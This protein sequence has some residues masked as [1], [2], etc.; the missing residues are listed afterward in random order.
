MVLGSLLSGGLQAHTSSVGYENAGPGAVTF[1]YGTYHTGVSA[2]EGSLLVTSTGGYSATVPFTLLVGTKPTGLIDGTTNFYSDGT[3]LVGTYSGTIHYWQGA[4]FTGLT[5]DTYTFTYQPITNPSSTWEPIDSVI[6]SSSVVLTSADL[7]GGMFSPNANT[8]SGGAAEVLDSLVGSATGDLAT[9]LTALA[10]LPADQQSA[11]LQHIAPQTNKALGAASAQTVSGAL[12]TVQ[13][14]MDAVRTGGFA[15]TL[16]DDFMSG[17]VMLA[18]SDPA[19]A[20]LVSDDPYPTRGAWGKVF[21][22]EG[23][24]GSVGGFAGYKANT[25][26]LSLGTDTLVNN[27]WVLG[28]AFTYANTDVALRDNFAGDGSDIKTYQLTGYFTRDFGKWYLEGMVAYARQDFNS[29]RDTTV[30]GVAEGNFNGDQWATRV[31]AGMPWALN[32]K[33]TLTPIAGLELNYFK[34]DGYTETGGGPLALTVDEQSATRVRSVLGGRVASK[35]DL[36]GGSVLKPSVH[37][38]WRHE[39][40]NGG[41][42][43]TAT[44]TGGGASFFTPGQKLARDMINVGGS[45]VYE[46]SKTFQL[47]LQLDG[48]RAPH[49]GAVS[50]Q[51]VGLWR[52]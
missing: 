9:V 33:V 48:E 6:L 34:Q 47:S 43:T 52:F 11:A 49:Y 44:F 14:R 28:V 24:Q 36:S 18:S 15:S 51:V 38:F 20:G 26:G 29:V 23:R 16:M 3:N 31:N 35:V 40:K 10:A 7:G 17:K 1:W 27:N 46:K 4:T 12:D 13:V 41:V 25:Y 8:R 21:G 50:G 45:L 32:N 30:S 5:P 22:S 37:L 42:D 39:F 2:T 19:A